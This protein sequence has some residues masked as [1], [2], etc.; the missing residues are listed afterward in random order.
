MGRALRGASVCAGAQKTSRKEQQ[1]QVHVGLEGRT[2]A[3]VRRL[4]TGPHGGNA[5][6][7]RKDVN[8]TNVLA[9]E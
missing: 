8:I 9:G 3:T 2:P 4:G 7:L 5:I 1:T 6:A